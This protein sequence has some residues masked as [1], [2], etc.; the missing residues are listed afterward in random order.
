MFVRFVKCHFLITAHFFITKGKICQWLQF[1]LKLFFLLEFKL[2]R[3]IF[4]I[5]SAEALSGQGSP[6][7]LM[8]QSTF[9]QSSF[10]YTHLPPYFEKKL[11]L[12]GLN[13]RWF[14][15]YFTGKRKCD[16]DKFPH[17]QFPYFHPFFLTFL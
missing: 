16:F 11:K 12:T 15:Y 10:S 6:N 7:P 8:K 13:F 9:S 17:N 4:Y 2:T 3:F 5:A 14:V 1:L